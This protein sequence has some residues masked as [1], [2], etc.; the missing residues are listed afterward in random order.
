MDVS[1]LVREIESAPDGN[2]PERISR[3]RAR[4]VSAIADQRKSRVRRRWVWGGSAVIGTVSA[5]AVV[6]TIVIAGAVAPVAPPPASAAA[7]AV[8]NGAADLVVDGLD[9]V[10]APGQYLRIR[11]TYD[12]VSLWDADADSGTAPEDEGIAGFNTSALPTSEGAVHT[13]GIRDLYVPGDRSEDWILDD[14]FVN[15]VV[16]VFGDPA[17]LPAYERMVKVAPERDADPGGIERLPGGLQTWDPE[18]ADDDAYYDPF[19]EFYDEMPRDPAAL[20]GWYREHLSTSD[21]DSYLF[22]AIGRYLSTD[23]MPADLRAAS[24][25]VLGLL[26]GV[27]VER[28]EGAVTT[29]VLRTDIGEGS[30][31]G[32]LLVSAIDIDT[33]TGRIVGIRESYPHRSTEL[34]PAG[35][36]WAGWV[37]EVSVVDEAPQP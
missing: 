15:E 26:G 1:E 19:R 14:R 36:P 5:A 8:L 30:G 35:L 24:L 32:D 4:L 2:A 33:A 28:T 29:L 12:V 17:T 31:F 23:L 27:E 22:S 7:V 25:R 6:A 3:S 13:R 11:E 18:Y 34:L 10:L 9:P 16:D 21:E 20:L 37:I